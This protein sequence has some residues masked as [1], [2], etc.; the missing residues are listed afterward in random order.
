MVRY[1]FNGRAPSPLCSTGSHLIVADSPDSPGYIIVKNGDPLKLVECGGSWPEACAP[2]R[3]ADG[4]WY[5][6]G[7]MTGFHFHFKCECGKRSLTPAY[8]MDNY[9]GVRK[10]GNRVVAWQCHALKDP[11]YGS[12]YWN[13]GW[14]FVH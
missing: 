14:V 6:R 12:E 9:G 2:S 8:C 3:D 4:V 13:Q 1:C 10:P 11:D 5:V 7:D